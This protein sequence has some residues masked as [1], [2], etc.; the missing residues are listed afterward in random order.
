[1]SVVVIGRCT[2]DALYRPV[3][4]RVVADEVQP[5]I[6]DAG[7]SGTQNSPT[8]TL[9][10]STPGRSA[11]TTITSTARA[12]KRNVSRPLDINSAS[13]DVPMS[14]QA[15]L[16]G[17]VPTQLRGGEEL[18]V[19]QIRGRQAEVI[20]IED[21]PVRGETQQMR[22]G[23]RT[24]PRQDG[25]ELEEIG[26]Q[27]PSAPI[28]AARKSK[29]SQ[30]LL[31]VVVP[32]PSQGDAPY[33]N[34]RAR[35]RSVSV[36]P[37]QVQSTAIDRRKKT[38]I[39][40]EVVEGSGSE[41]SEG[42]GE[43]DHKPD[44]MERPSEPLE[45]GRFTEYMEIDEADMQLQY[46]TSMVSTS[47]ADDDMD[48]EFEALPNTSLQQDGTDALHSPDDE[49]THRNLFNEP[50]EEEDSVSVVTVE[51]QETQSSSN[52]YRVDNPEDKHPSRNSSKHPFEES[53]EEEEPSYET[54]PSRHLS[55]RSDRPHA[56][57][58]FSERGTEAEFPI[59]TYSA[60][61]SPNRSIQR[62]GSSTALHSQPSNP[63]SS[64]G[65]HTLVNS[66]TTSSHTPNLYSR[67]V[68]SSNTPSQPAN[69]SVMGT[70]ARDILDQTNTDTQFRPRPGTRAHAHDVMSKARAR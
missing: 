51:V 4:A 27:P 18:P 15:T 11:R 7:P 29:R 8:Q 64:L 30:M 50:Q 49:R 68:Y 43:L 1:M 10:P 55:T 53:D 52:M 39:L 26:R 54:Q 69:T 44:D 32:Q 66:T 13:S 58:T 62:P 31:G 41:E 5:E 48:Q 38:K 61:L 36:E 23:L 59:R 40:T 9:A 20:E 24:R 46:D 22:T 25:P 47:L 19:T 70:Y 35:A 60:V 65:S 2:Y 6:E 12:T 14:S 21:S 33:R 28:T 45:Q 17:P 56:S 63:R 42:G 16:V 57:R 67:R 37:V 34:T 3:E